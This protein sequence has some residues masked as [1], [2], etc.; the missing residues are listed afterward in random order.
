MK[1]NKKIKIKVKALLMLST[2]LIANLLGLANSVQA[3]DGPSDTRLE[4]LYSTGTCNN[5]IAY[6]GIRCNLLLY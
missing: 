5:M 2:I 3:Y 4:N 6:K 1:K